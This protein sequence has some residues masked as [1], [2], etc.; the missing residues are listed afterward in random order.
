MPL[1]QLE[2]VEKNLRRLAKQLPVDEVLILR[3]AV[4]LGRDINALL[5]RRLKPVGL[6]EAE[7]R[8]LLSLLAQGGN[9][10]AG[11]LCAAL[12]QSP[13]N[14]TRIGDALVERGLISRDPD[15]AD[16][17]RMLLTLLPAGEQ[18]MGA[19]LPQVGTEVSR[20]FAGF[21][22]TDRS[23]LLDGFRRLMAGVDAMAAQPTA[24]GDSP[25]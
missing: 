12:A 17:R 15:A 3:A 13:A 22:R 11:D 10:F 20:L 25:E 18:L 1:A 9:A 24:S 21:N 19:L 7:F 4:I 5:D 2:S 16:R 23:A 6:T 14:L 8:V